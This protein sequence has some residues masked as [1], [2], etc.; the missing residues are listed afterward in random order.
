[1]NK[2][3]TVNY[4][5][6]SNLFCFII[7]HVHSTERTQLVWNIVPDVKIG[8]DGGVVLNTSNFEVQ[9]TLIKHNPELYTWNDCIRFW[10]SFD[11][12]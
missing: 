4:K 5:T 1:M 12:Q 10:F 7:G 11:L 3:Q 8:Q 9:D 6:M 2:G